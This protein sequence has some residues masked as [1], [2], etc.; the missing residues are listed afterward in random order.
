MVAPLRGRVA[1]WAAALALALLPLVSTAGEARAQV[2]TTGPWDTFVTI[3]FGPSYECTIDFLQTGTDLAISGTCPIGTIGITGTIDPGTGHFA[4]AGTF[5]TLCPTATLNSDSQA[6]LDNKT[7]HFSVTCSGGPLPLLIGFNG[8]RCGNGVID[9]IAGETC[10]DGNRGGG[11]CCSSTCQSDP[12]G[13]T[14]LNDGNQCT[15]DVCDINATCTHSNRSG[16]CDDGNQCTAGDT[17]LSGI[18]VGTA[19]PD[20]TVCDDFN[21]CTN[22]SCQGGTCTSTNKVDGSPCNDFFDCTT[23]ETCLGGQC[24]IGAPVVCPACE[25][26]REGTGCFPEVFPEAAPEYGLEDFIQLRKT[27]PD[28]A[29][30]KWVASRDLTIGDFGDPTTTSAYEFCVFDL[31]NIDPVSNGPTLMFAAP[32]PAGGNW[33]QNASGFRFKS[34][35]K[36][37]VRFKIG[38]AGKAK[39]LLKAKGPAYSVQYLPPVSN[40]LSVELRTADGVQP[41]IDFGASYGN[42][43]TS[44]SKEYKDQNVPSSP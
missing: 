7:I 24:Q 41:A 37:K 15:D 26:C 27:D 17:C 16:A 13:T 32:V 33:K 42:P 9:A 10:D 14:C 25:R 35:D 11:D 6:S 34:S 30:W 43:I 2:D 18:C 22:D 40:L 28:S 36:L 23:G 19:V 39:I 12:P 31:L 4:G 21:D 1:H 3:I 20:G 5:G 8:F 38:K 44:T 29:K